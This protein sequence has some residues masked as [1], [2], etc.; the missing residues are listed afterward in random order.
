MQSGNRTAVHP[1]DNRPASPD[2]V[3][4]H[5]VPNGERWDVLRDGAFL[6]TIVGDLHAAIGHAVAAAQREQ[7]GGK[8]ASVCVEENDGHCRHLWP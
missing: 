8:K 5:V 3:D 4:Y 1:E 7:Q 2:G 6:A